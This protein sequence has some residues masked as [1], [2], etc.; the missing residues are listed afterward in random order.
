VGVNADMTIRG[1]VMLLTHGRQGSDRLIGAALLLDAVLD[2]E[3]D[4]DGGYIVAGPE[5][6]DSPLVAELRAR[7]M[8]GPPES[9]LAWIERTAQFAPARTAAELIR[10]GVASPLARR[11]QREFTLSVDA[12][13]EAAARERVVHNPAV[14]ALLWDSGLGGLLPPAIHTL[15][16]A[17]RAILAAFRRTAPVADR[18]AA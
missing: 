1:D 11:F 9:P 3:L 8:A 4:I 12:R 16:P 2:N 5:R 14:A 6:A 13:A 15:P 10:A 18:L 17:A 7:V